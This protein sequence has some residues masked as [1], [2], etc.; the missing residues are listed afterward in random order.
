MRTS[1]A[2][3]SPPWVRP[4]GDLALDVAY[5]LARHA[6]TITEEWYRQIL[7]EGMDTL[8]W[9]EIVG[10]VVAT[11][12]VV[13]FTRAIGNSQSPLPAA[14]LLASPPVASRPS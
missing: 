9:I 4:F 3:P 7:D 1:T 2:D 12:P 5:R 14:E 13:A 11:V 8:E 6:G 10:I